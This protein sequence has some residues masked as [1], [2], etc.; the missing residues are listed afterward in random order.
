MRLVLVSMFSRFP[1]NIK[2]VTLLAH[3][4]MINIGLTFRAVMLIDCLIVIVNA[5]SLIDVNVLDGL[6][7]N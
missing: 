5:S 4:Y 7:I 3:L 2:H 6:K 1:K